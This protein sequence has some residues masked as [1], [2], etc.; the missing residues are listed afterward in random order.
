MDGLVT[1]LAVGSVGGSVGGWVSGSSV[2]P[3]V[4]T[5]GS[6]KQN[7]DRMKDEKALLLFML[8]LLQ[9]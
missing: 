9:R 2:G 4:K 3:A 7:P 8:H 6:S 1:L 5:S